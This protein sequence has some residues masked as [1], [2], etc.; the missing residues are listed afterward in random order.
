MEDNNKESLGIVS[1]LLPLHQTENVSNG[2]KIE[3]NREVEMRYS[4]NLCELL[5]T[6]G[7]GVGLSSKEVT[8]SSMLLKIDTCPKSPARTTAHDEKWL[9]R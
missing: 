6:D 2:N 4:P 7:L 9:R 3:V 1:M 5:T 8:L